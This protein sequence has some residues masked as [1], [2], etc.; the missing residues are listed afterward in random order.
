MVGRSDFISSCDVSVD[1]WHLGRYDGCF[2]R[3][4]TAEE[5]VRMI[6]NHGEVAPKALKDIA[7]DRLEELIIRDQLKGG[8][9]L[10]EIDLAK[11]LGI[12]RTPVREALQRLARDGL[13]VILPRRGVMV[14]ESNVAEQLRVLEVRRPLQRLTA[15][16]AARR[17]TAMQR[18]TML[19]YASV[20]EEHG[21][22][23]LGEEFFLWTRKSH[24]LL[25]EAAHNEIIKDVMAPLHARSRRFWYNHYERYG[26]LPKASEVHAA[27]LRNISVGDETLAE[28]SAD[29]LIA[30]LEGFARATIAAY[31]NG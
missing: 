25:E 28:Q 14:A 24:M 7:Y 27:L 23:R 5:M 29:A 31:S 8:S 13:V 10:S 9:M 18:M 19:E 6:Q 2:D 4:V 30:Y 21:S 20:L 16:C 22:A 17:A 15:L 12:G 26:D 11:Q 3:K 1:V